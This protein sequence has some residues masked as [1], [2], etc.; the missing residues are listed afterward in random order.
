MIIIIKRHF[1]KVA[2]VVKI[3]VVTIRS[4]NCDALHNLVPV[5]QFKKREKHP[6]RSVTFSKVASLACNITKS[7][8]PPWFFFTFFKLCKWCQIAQRITRKFFDWF[9]SFV[10]N[11]LILEDQKIFNKARLTITTICVIAK[12][13]IKFSSQYLCA[14]LMKT[15]FTDLTRNCLLFFSKHSS[16]KNLFIKP[17]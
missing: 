8:T 5:V 10:G 17:I 3:T 7:N 12:C 2:T 6:W 1:Y 4:N 11:S 15:S 16:F 14:S 9:W 13:Q